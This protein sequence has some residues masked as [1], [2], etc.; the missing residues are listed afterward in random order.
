MKV[1]ETER[2]DTHN[3]ISDPNNTVLQKRIAQMNYLE[4]ENQNLQMENEDLSTTLKINKDIIQSLLTGDRKFDAQFE[5]A[6]A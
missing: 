5:Y 4:S 1:L 2:E 6:F 3:E